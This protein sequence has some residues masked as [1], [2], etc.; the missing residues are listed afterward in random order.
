MQ[1]S[2][3]LGLILAV[4]ATSVSGQSDSLEVFRDRHKLVAF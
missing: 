4:I 1:N 3:I 2:K